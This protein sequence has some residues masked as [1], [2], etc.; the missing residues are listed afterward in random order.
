MLDTILAK[1]LLLPGSYSLVDL[2]LDPEKIRRKLILVSL[3]SNF[4]IEYRRAT[5]FRGYKISRI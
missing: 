4:F 3:E 5:Y 1:R 2:R